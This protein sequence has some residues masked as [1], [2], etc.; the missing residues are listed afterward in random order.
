ME[1]IRLGRGAL[2]GIFDKAAQNFTVRFPLREERTVESL[3]YQP[4]TIDWC[5]DQM[6][7]LPPVSIPMFPRCKSPGL[8]GSFLCR[9]FG[10]G[11]H[12][13]T[14]ERE[15]GAGSGPRACLALVEGREPRAAE[16]EARIA[17]GPTLAAGSAGRKPAH[18]CSYLWG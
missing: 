16:L 3:D 17:H 15:L 10:H 1:R 14:R 11:F 18:E 2:L 13:S 7:A 5:G 4:F 8:A 9:G 6:V 12:F